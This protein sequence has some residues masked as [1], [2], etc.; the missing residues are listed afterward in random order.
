MSETAKRILCLTRQSPHR[1]L[2]GLEGLDVILTAAAFEQRV[3][4]AFVDD[5]VWQL[6]SH[7]APEQIGRKNFAKGYR[8]LEHY[9]VE[10]VVVDADSLTARGL[11]A[12]DLLMP[13]EVLGRD[14]LSALIDSQD[15]VL[16]F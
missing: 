16:T 4:V 11:V 2:S 10:R 7:Q 6:K 9:D 8:A 1:T 15:V 5:G 3:T 13:V 12:K 14:E